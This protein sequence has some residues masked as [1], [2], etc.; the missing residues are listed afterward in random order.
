[1]RSEQFEV[2]ALVKLEKGMEV[3]FTVVNQDMEEVETK[4]FQNGEY[5]VEDEM[6]QFLRDCDNSDLYVY[7]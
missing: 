6:L 5:N 3:E 7:M 4:C 2:E 1:M